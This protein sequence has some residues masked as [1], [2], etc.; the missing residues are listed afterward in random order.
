M[1]SDPAP[2]RYTCG[3]RRL[4]SLVLL[5]AFAGPLLAS[6]LAVAQGPES[7][8]PACCRRNGAHHCMMSADQ[9]SSLLNGTHFTVIPSKCP[10]YP[11]ALAPVHHQNC[12]FNAPS[13]LLAVAYAH[14][15]RRWQ[16]EAWARAAL[17]GARQKRGP[18]SL[19]RS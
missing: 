8:L 3:V 2:P 16:V 10:A 6:A 17:A 18:P 4:L 11:R 15:A 12:L 7:N 19:L 14:P 9:L 13:N 5:A 1:H